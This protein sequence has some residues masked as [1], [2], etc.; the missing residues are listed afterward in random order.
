MKVT[1]ETPE[2]KKEEITF[3]CLIGYDLFEDKNNQIILAT[4]YDSTGL[5]IGTVVKSGSHQLG[6]FSKGWCSRQGKPLPKGTK[7]ILEN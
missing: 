3:P 4:G 1:I 2:D 7:V 6:Y 5:F